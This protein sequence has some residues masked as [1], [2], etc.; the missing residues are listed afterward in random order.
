[1]NK[2]TKHRIIFFVTML[3]AS[4]ITFSVLFL[5]PLIESGRAPPNRYTVQRAAPNFVCFAEI[6][7]LSPQ[8]RTKGLTFHDLKRNI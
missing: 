3:L 6:Q 8:I 1:M 7:R 2:H 4:L 5:L